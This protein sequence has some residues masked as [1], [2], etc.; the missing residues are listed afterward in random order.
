M[1]QSL[2]LILSVADEGPNQRQ[3]KKKINNSTYFNKYFKDI[4]TRPLQK[5]QII[6]YSS[7]RGKVED[8]RPLPPLCCSHHLRVFRNPDKLV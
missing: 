1:T 6:C 4:S 2:L 8:K 7:F 3:Q 5:K